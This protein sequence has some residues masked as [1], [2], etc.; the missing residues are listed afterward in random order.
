MSFEAYITKLV[1]DFKDSWNEKQLETLGDLL[2]EDFIITTPGLIFTNV[3][4]QSHRI[5]GK[6]AVLKFMNKSRKKLP[7][8][9]TISNIKISSQRTVQ[10]KAHYFEIDVS[11]I[12]ELK[13]SRHGKFDS[14]TINR[15]EDTKGTKIST[16][17]ILK[18][19]LKHKLK[20]YF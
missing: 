5:T 15:L 4:I 2:S 8:R 14:L 10:L 11:S 12:F 3:S 20:K 9:L 19:I 6:E 13:I 16:I 18:N 1:N 17:Y 7:L